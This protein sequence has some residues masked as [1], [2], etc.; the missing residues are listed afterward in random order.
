MTADDEVMSNEADDD[1]DGE[2]EVVGNDEAV[3]DVTSN[4][5]MEE[6]T[7]DKD[8]GVADITEEFISAVD[9]TADDEVI[10]NEANDDKDGE[11]E[12]DEAVEV[13]SNEAD[14]KAPIEAGDDKDEKNE[15]DGND[16]MVVSDN[17]E[18]ITENI[19][20]KVDGVVDGA[21]DDKGD[22]VIFGEANGVKNELVSK[23]KS[24][25]VLQF[26]EQLLLKPV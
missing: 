19:I 26:S 20:E 1:K 2:N 17:I 21:S 4:D 8:E 25:V 7:D 23:S 12:I 6:V 9:E 15:V 11:N 16:E 5:D 24:I 10:F 18:G 13:V 14:D 3:N 22:E